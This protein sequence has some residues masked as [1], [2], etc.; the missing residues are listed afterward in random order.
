M[1]IYFYVFW[2]NNVKCYSL[3]DKIQKFLFQ[4]SHK[5][6]WLANCYK[7]KL[8]V[9][10]CEEVWYFLFFYK[11]YLYYI[12]LM[13]QYTILIFVLLCFIS[14]ISS[15]L[16]Q[17]LFYYTG[18]TTCLCYSLL[19]SSVQKSETCCRFIMRLTRFKKSVNVNHFIL[20]ISNVSRL[21]YS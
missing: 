20:C 21:V 9:T 14:R 10:L 3:W 18:I 17:M 13:K 12:G 19:P 5:V 1:L 8:T 2:R 6:T 16:I 11:Q 15:F 4:L 7:R